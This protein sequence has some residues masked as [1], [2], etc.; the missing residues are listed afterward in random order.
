MK[1]DKPT[2]YFDFLRQSRNRQEL[3]T[4][5]VAEL[6]DQYAQGAKDE[7]I[8]GSIFYITDYIK[9]S[10]S[11]GNSYSGSFL[12][13]K[14]CSLRDADNSFLNEKRNSED[15]CVF[16]EQIFP[17]QMSFLEAH[18]AEQDV[19]YSFT[20]NFRV[21]NASESWSFVVQR[22]IYLFN[23]FYKM[24]IASLNWIT[25]VT[26]FKGDSKISHLIQRYDGQTERK[27]VERRSYFLKNT[28]EILSKREVDVLKLASLGMASREIASKL[29]ISIH[30]INNH[31]RNMLV[32]CNCKNIL[33]LVD[34]A[35]KNGVI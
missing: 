35:V 11:F 10:N 31:R 14:I 1:V 19:E 17:D 28:Q 24:P 26:D 33:Q 4:L 23:R 12:G 27:I 20:T 34:I 3:E 13:Y 22:T 15:L 8:F 21:K 18:Q 6:T 32:R 5:K 29:N 25:D 16:N 2:V 7:N 9:N 30:P